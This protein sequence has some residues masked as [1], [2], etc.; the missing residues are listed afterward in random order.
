MAAGTYFACALDGSSFGVCLMPNVYSWI[1]AATLV[2]ALSVGGAANASVIFTPG[3]NPQPG[4]QNV[5]FG[6]SQ[7]GTTITGANNQSKTPDQFTSTHSLTGGVC[8]AVLEPTNSATLLANFAFS[9]PGNTFGDF[10]F[11]PQ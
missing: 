2:S 10:I 11:N 1:A 6:S 4:E 3:N 7:T 5:L 9:V 8:Q